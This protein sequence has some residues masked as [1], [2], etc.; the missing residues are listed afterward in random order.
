MRDTG[1]ELPDGL[2]LLRLQQRLLGSLPFGDLGGQSVVRGGEAAGSLRDQLFQLLAAAPQRL[3]RLDDIGNIRA[4]AEPSDGPALVPNR[5]RACLEPSILA[6][7]ATDPKLQIVVV[8]ASNRRHPALPNA[9]PILWMDDLVEP[10][11]P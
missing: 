11:E 7:G 6:V 9:L 10:S 5:G 8:P 2:E 4:G 1:G 3:A